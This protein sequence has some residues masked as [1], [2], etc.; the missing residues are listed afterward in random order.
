[1]K[2]LSILIIV[3]FVIFVIPTCDKSPTSSKPNLN[4]TPME[5][6]EAELLALWLS[7]SV[8]APSDLYTTIRNDLSLIRSTWKNRIPE[9]QFKFIPSQ[10]PSKLFILFDQDTFEAIVA[11]NYHAWDKLNEDFSVKEIIARDYSSFVVLNF[12]GRLNPNVLVDYYKELPGAKLIDTPTG[13]SGLSPLI[14]DGEGEHLIY[15]FLGNWPHDVNGGSLEKIN[16]FRI[17]NG[18]VVHQYEREGI[19]NIWDPPEW[20]AMVYR[21]IQNYSYTNSWVKE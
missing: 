16:C 14:I 5:N 7:N 20:M 15:Y 21:A 4:S 13:F 12:E 3:I 8:V 1:M 2:K 9:V 18:I 10:I 11:G 17:M 19:I 6:E